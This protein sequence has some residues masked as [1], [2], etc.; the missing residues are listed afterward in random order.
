MKVPSH[1]VNRYTG[2][3]CNVL[4]CT[5][6]GNHI[7]LKT[8]SDCVVFMDNG[9]V[10]YNSEWIFN[11]NNASSY[12]HELDAEIDKLRKDL[13]YLKDK[14]VRLSE[15]LEKVV[16]QEIDI[17]DNRTC[18][19]IPRKRE[20]KTEKEV[21]DFIFDTPKRTKIKDPIREDGVV[22]GTVRT[23]NKTVEPVKKSKAYSLDEFREELLQSYNID[24]DLDNLNDF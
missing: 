17:P 24:L 16:V 7:I 23:M 15:G 3:V 8:K 11:Y 14:R 4:H 6:L 18:F 21:I 22:V 1:I 2:E 9:D 19:F 12:L 5:R 20:T 10:L 13:K